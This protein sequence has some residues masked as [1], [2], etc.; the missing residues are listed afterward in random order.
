[1]CMSLLEKKTHLI[2]LPFYFFICPSERTLLLSARRGYD[3]PEKQIHVGLIRAE[4]KIGVGT[5]VELVDIPSPSEL[6]I[7]LSHFIT[8][9]SSISQ[10]YLIEI[11]PEDGKQSPKQL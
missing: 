8:Y 4:L 2:A 6:L 9:L 11:G 5:L 3:L 7:W 10:K 1:M